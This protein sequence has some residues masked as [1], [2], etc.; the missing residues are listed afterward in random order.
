[1]ANIRAS[2]ESL[3]NIS[4]IM[5]VIFFLLSLII[6]IFFTEMVYLPLRKITA[7]TEQYAAGNLHYEFQV[8]S[9]DEIGYLAASLSLMAS[10]IARAEDNQKKFIANVSH[11]FRSP[12]TSIKGYLEAMLDGTIPPELHE[13][14]LGIVLNETERLT[15]L[16]NSLLTLN[17]LNMKGMIL[18]K[19][20]FDLNSVIR[21]TAAS[22]EGTCQQK[23]IGIELLLTGDRMPVLADKSKIEQVL[24]NLLDNAIKFSHPDSAI[25]IE[26]NEKHGKVFVSVKDSGIGIPK[27]SLRLIFDRFY[28]TDLSRGKD[29]KGT[30]L[31]LSITKEI[32]QAHNENINVISTEGVGSEFIFS[33][34]GTDIL[35]HRNAD[36][37]LFILHKD[38]LRDSGTL[39]AE[40]NIIVRSDLY[41]AVNLMRFRRRHPELRRIRLAAY[42]R[43][44]FFQKVR[45]IDVAAHIQQI[46]VI[47]ACAL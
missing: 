1:M 23:H 19:S 32:I 14:Y 18:E 15:K 5:L 12:L 36:T 7:A 35:S 6:L 16:T 44:I 47:H 3:L 30:G 29:K 38:F 9:E 42:K 37:A 28:K 13:K 46:P 22:F 31:G 39:L 10:E 8:D 26:T 20:V 24:Y 27:D 33:L 17:N 43:R 45:K 34:Q 41:I 4:Y 40:H 2:S 21:S 25:R 11:D